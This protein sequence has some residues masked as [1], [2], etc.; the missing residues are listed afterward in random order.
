MRNNG[1][2]V[3][4]RRKRRR[5]SWL[6]RWP[7]KPKKIENNQ[8]KAIDIQGARGEMVVDVQEAQK[9]QNVI[10]EKGGPGLKRR[11]TIGPSAIIGKNMFRS[12]KRCENVRR[13]LRKMR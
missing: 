8:S 6:D 2:L 10:G 9:M 3:E 7:M 13:M 5:G 11:N 4:R 1:L 12:R